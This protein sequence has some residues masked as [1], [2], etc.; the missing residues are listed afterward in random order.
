MHHKS[1]IIINKVLFMRSYSAFIV[2]L[3]FHG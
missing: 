1:A 3:Y 2:M